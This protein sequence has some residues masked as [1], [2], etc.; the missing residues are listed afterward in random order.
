MSKVT[1]LFH[2]TG[3]KVQVVRRLSMAEFAEI[4]DS[5]SISKSRSITKVNS[6]HDSDATNC[7]Q[8]VNSHKICCNKVSIEIKERIIELALQYPEWGCG[9]IANDLKILNISLSRQAIHKL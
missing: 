9:K 7:L 1:E 6:A 4:L 3:K 8:S 5:V 2:D